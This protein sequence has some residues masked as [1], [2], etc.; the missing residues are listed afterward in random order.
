[1]AAPD[2]YHA[3]RHPGILDTRGD[4]GLLPPECDLSWLA[5]TTSVL[6]HAETYLLMR[7]TLQMTPGEY[8]KWLGVTWRRM[9]AA[10]QN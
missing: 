3:R 7:E 9:A 1:M 6:A 4:D 2:V 8:E 10:A 5:D